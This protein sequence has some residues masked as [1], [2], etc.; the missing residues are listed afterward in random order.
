VQTQSNI[1][2]RRDTTTNP[3]ILPDLICIVIN[4]DEGMVAKTGHKK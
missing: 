3:Y 4:A 2:S 1:P